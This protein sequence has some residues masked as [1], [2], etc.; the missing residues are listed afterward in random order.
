MAA[1]RGGPAGRDARRP[2][3]PGGRGGGSPRVRRPLAV[4]EVVGPQRP[5]PASQGPRTESL[6]AAVAMSPDFAFVLGFVGGLL[7]G[8]IGGL[9][10]ALVLGQRG[11]RK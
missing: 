9:V 3:A 2:A 8:G 6:P 11:E 5:R 1:D 4:G 7:L 10:L